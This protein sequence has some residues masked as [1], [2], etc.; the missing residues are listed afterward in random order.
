M[1]SFNVGGVSELVVDGQT[2]ILVPPKDSVAL[3]KAISKLLENK[4]EATK[5]GMA[6]QKRLGEG[7]GLEKMTRSYEEI[8]SQ[9]IKHRKLINHR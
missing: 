5:M 3:A 7:F 1:V 4:K 6:G 2:G 8:Y 9:A